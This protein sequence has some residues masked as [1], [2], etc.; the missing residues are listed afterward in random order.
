MRTLN[1]PAPPDQYDPAYMRRLV[2]SITLWGSQFTYPVEMRMRF[3]DGKD[4]P[5]VSIL[6]TLASGTVYNDTSAA[7]VLKVKP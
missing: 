6:A 2:N 7:N 5:T 4:L 1:L 3:I